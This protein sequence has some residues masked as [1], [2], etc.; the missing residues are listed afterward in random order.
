[1]S[2]KCHKQTFAAAILAS[3]LCP[4]PSK[5]AKQ[6]ARAALPGIA[7]AASVRI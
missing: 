1:M 2:V 4:S 7:A 3:G 6:V 5:R